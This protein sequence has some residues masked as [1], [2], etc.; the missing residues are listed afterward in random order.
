MLNLGSKS[1]KMFYAAFSCCL[2][3]QIPARGIKFQ[4]NLYDNK[5]LL[6]IGKQEC[7]FICLL[8]KLGSP[9]F[10]RGLSCIE[11]MQRLGLSIWLL[12]VKLLM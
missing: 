6:K 10:Y 8:S 3:E 12:L 9:K 2:V 5:L 4:G 11:P 1:H 7:M